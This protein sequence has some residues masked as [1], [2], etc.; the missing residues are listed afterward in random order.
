MRPYSGVSD[1][2]TILAFGTL[3]VYEA[4]DRSIED[5]TRDG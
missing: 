1:G 3:V 4:L 2:T 5:V